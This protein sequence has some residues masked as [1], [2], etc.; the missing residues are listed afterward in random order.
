MRSD[1]I[2]SWSIFILLTIIWG[3][4][5]ILMKH[6]VE[7]LTGPQIAALRIFS[8]G[9]VFLPFAIF[10]LR[11]VPS[12]KLVVV[13]LSGVTGNLCP[14]FLYAVAIAK[15]ID[16][17]L[18]SILNSFTPI[19]V[20]LIAII[21]FR[22]KIRKQKLLGVLLG[23]AGLFLLFA[24]QKQVSFE[25]MG[26]ASLIL[27][28]TISYGINVNMVSHYLKELNPIH[29]ASISIGTMVIPT[30]FILWYEN[31]FQ[32]SFHD[33]DT[34]FAV[35]EA[36]LLGVAGTAIATAL[37]YVLIKKA[38][39]IFA[40][41]VTYAIPIVGIFWGIV[42]GETVTAMMGLALGI[43]LCGVYLANK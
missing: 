12:K 23:F 40:S 24:F 10:H 37:F 31:F 33:Y 35:L 17:S 19:F 30:F 21:F 42:D 16:S 25:N 2:I 11:K 26:Y 3:S 34:Q 9:L 22:D 8:A 4:S 20:V 18:A 36:V 32:L 29:V 14:A 15:K 13:I 5:F 7:Q 1:K 39:G 6:S 28:A 41:L 38:G 27:L 43:I